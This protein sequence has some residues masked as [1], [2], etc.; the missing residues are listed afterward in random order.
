MAQ[1]D[2]V[3]SKQT[4]TLLDASKA[5][6]LIGFVNGLLGSKGDNDIDVTVEDS[7]RLVISLKEGAVPDGYVET[8]VV[9][10]DDGE[11]VQGK[12]LFKID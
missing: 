11:N 10:C 4:P 8:A 12:I 5:N 1:I 2:K 9:L 7:G 6:E 3:I